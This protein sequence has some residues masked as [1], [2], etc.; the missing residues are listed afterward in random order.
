MR[1]ES[2]L[3]NGNVYSPVH[4]NPNDDAECVNN[5][6][7]NIKK[8]KSF[9]GYLFFYLSE[10]FYM[11]AIAFLVNASYERWYSRQQSVI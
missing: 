1:Q 11:L 5:N 9:Y 2:S 6:D 7:N 8:S 10:G 3:E 4:Q